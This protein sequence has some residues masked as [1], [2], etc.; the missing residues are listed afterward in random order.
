MGSIDQVA[1]REEEEFS[2]TMVWL[3]TLRLLDLLGVVD[4]RLS[5]GLLLFACN[6][7]SITDEKFDGSGH[8]VSDHTGLL[9]VHSI[10]MP[11]SLAV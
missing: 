2:A 9:L 5:E 1:C 8:N 7:S 10:T 3:S 4:F 11:S 6:A